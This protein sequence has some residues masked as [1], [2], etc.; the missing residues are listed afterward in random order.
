MIE[1]GGNIYYIDL[2]ALEDSISTN[3]PKKNETISLTN[4]TVTKDPNGEVLSTVVVTSLSPKVRE[5]DITKF[6]I[7][8]ELIDVVLQYNDDEDSSLGADRALEKTPLS[9]K[10]AFNTLYDYGII[11]EK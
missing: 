5:V 4:T 9:Y 1:F 6:E 3:E 7:I 2:S 10:I 8:R 11:K